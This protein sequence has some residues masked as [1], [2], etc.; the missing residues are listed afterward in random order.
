[1]T[2]VGADQ[3]L[4]QLKDQQETEKEQVSGHLEAEELEELHKVTGCRCYEYWYASLLVRIRKIPT[5]TIFTLTPSFWSQFIDS[6]GN[7]VIKY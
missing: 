5:Y 3:L 1:M 6:P 7:I 4:K 2:E